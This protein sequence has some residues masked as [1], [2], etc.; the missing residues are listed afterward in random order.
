M[1]SSIKSTVPRVHL[2]STIKNA[3][4]L[5]GF[6]GL[7]FEIVGNKSKP[8]LGDVDIAIDLNE[9]KKFIVI[10]DSNEDVWDLLGEYL[11]SRKVKEFSI[12]KGLKQFHLS[13]PLVDDSTTELN[14]FDKN[15]NQMAYPGMIQLDVF[16]GDRNWM[17][18]ILSGTESDSEFKAVYRNLLLTAITSQIKWPNPLGP[19][20]AYKRYTMDFKEGLRLRGYKTI[21]PT[22]RRKKPK[23]ELLEDII[24][25]N[26]PNMLIKILF[27][28]EYNWSNADTFEKMYQLF[29]GPG[30][31][32][33]KF[34]NEIIQDFIGNLKKLEKP[35]PEKVSSYI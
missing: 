5:A 21:P 17:K 4:S 6:D 14:G 23:R 2:E 20:G 18:S 34:K 13:V 29:S 7:K 31:K 28:N 16:V 12:I 3:I 9:L 25:S 24:L 8:F 10:N 26:D 1:F 30:F 27:G 33:K 19:S 32:Y 22:G 11:T 35:I 15:G